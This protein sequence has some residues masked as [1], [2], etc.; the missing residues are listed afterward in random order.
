MGVGVGVLHSKEYTPGD[1]M[2]GKLLTASVH[3]RAVRA[4][5]IEP[6]CQERQGYDYVNC[7]LASCRHL[8]GNQ[9]VAEGTEGL[10]LCTTGGN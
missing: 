2:G 4:A 8:L 7:V 9:E 10:A 6:T 1:R 3:L 5:A